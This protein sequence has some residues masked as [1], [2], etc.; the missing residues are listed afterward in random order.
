[1]RLKTKI[2][3]PAWIAMVVAALLIVK[4]PAH[5]KAASRESAEA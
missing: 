4:T 1:M 2:L 5:Q 3:W